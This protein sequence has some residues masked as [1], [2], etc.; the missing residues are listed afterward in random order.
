MRC[1]CSPPSARRLCTMRHR[2]DAGRAGRCTSARRPSSRLPRSAPE[3]FPREDVLMVLDVPAAIGEYQIKFGHSRRVFATIGERGAVRSPA[4]D[5]G[6]LSRWNGRPVAGR[7]PR[8]ASGTQ[9][10]GGDINLRWPFS[11]LCRS[12]GPQHRKGCH[13]PRD[14]LRVDPGAILAQRAFADVR[15]VNR[16]GGGHCCKINKPTPQERGTI[17]R[18]RQFDPAVPGWIFWPIF[19]G[20]VLILASFVLSIR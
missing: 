14:K 7:A 18:L 5:F 9:R 6:L 17:Q 4:S 8:R 1:T 3:K 12:E 19:F 16:R 13:A 2:S 11:P 20:V 10:W 15:S